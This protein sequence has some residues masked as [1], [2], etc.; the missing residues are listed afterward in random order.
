M[1]TQRSTV[2]G[3]FHERQQA[4][5]AVEELRRAGFEDAHLGVALRDGDSTKSTTSAP[6]PK[7][8]HAAIGLA[9][10]VGTGAG[11]GALWAVG[12]IA[13]LL[14]AIGP[15]IL[16]G[17]LFAAIL[18]SLPAGSG[19]AGGLVGILVGTWASRRMRPNTM[20]RRIQERQDRGDGPGR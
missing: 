6:D 7:A 14:P 12:I 2:V 9:A 3:V 17:G 15:V 18:A 8:E 10:G 4:Q 19:A 1:N 11:L 20:R 13:G 16:G 5:R